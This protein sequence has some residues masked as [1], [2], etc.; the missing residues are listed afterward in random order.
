MAT[1][2]KIQKEKV[3]KYTPASGTVAIYNNTLKKRK[4]DE[5]SFDNEVDEKSLDTTNRRSM[6]SQCNWNKK[7]V[8]MWRTFNWFQ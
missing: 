4:A 8:H 3:T 5:S 6:V 2:W 1:N 7:A